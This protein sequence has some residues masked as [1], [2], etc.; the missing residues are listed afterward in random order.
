MSTK[1]AVYLAAVDDTNAAPHVTDVASGMAAATSPAELHV[2]HVIALF[3]GAGS[4]Y[5]GAPVGP[6]TEAMNRG[7]RRLD[8]IVALAQ[9]RF[10]GRVVGHL[11]AGEPWR[12]ILQLA[13]NID[14]DLIV[15][16]TAGRTGLRRLVLG[17]VAERVTRKA[18]C[19]VL[20][21]RRKDYHG[22]VD[23]Q[24]APPCPECLAVQ[25]ETNRA[26]LWCAQHTQVHPKPHTHYELPEGYGAGSMLIR[27]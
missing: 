13:A 22:R 20:V 4:G 17:S 11:A 16:G 23:P 26:E 10:D 15:V 9:E 7:R 27:P 3:A 2:I 18:Q 12:E 25:R 5:P 19:P 21:A 24:I 14:A 1:P 8:E 6:F